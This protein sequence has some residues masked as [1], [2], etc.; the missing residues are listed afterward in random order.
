ML[1][2]LLRRLAE[3]AAGVRVR[4]LVGIGRRLLAVLRALSVLHRLTVRPLRLLPVR[5][6]LVRIRRLLLPVATHGN[7]ITSARI[8]M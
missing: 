7:K 1:A 3:V 4:L 5:I 8:R 6:L 2:G